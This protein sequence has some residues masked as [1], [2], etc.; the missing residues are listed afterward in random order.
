MLEAGKQKIT[1]SRTEKTE[2]K[3]HQR[4]TKATKWT[5]HNSQNAP[6]LRSLSSS[7][8]GNQGGAQQKYQA[9]WEDGSGTGIVFFNLPKPLLKADKAT[10]I[11]KLKM[12]RQH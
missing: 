6:K 4:I 2:S 3:K 5:L 10:K 7:R 9:F 8:C 12:Y 1:D 11:A